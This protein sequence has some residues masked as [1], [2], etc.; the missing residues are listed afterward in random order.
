MLITSKFESQCKTC[1]KTVYL[2]DRCSWTKG[3]KGIRCLGC[4][5]D[6]DLPPFRDRKDLAAPNGQAPWLKVLAAC[7]EAILEN[8]AVTLTPQLEAEWAKYQKLKALALAPGHEQEGRAALRQALL[9][10][11]K[12]AI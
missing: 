3:E 6:D 8:A 9:T 10:A 2:G 4:A 12:L 11:I 7:E 5:P 1:R